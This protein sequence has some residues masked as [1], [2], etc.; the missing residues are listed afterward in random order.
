MNHRATI[1]C[2]ILAQLS[3]LSFSALGAQVYFSDAEA[4]VIYRAN[5]DG[6][7]VTPV[8]DTGFTSWTMPIEVDPVGQRIYWAEVGNSNSQIRSSNYSGGDIQ[9]LVDSTNTGSILDLELDL[10]NQHI[11]WTDR[12][13][14]RIER[15]NL[16]EADR[17][18]VT[19]PDPNGP[20][21]ISELVGIA[22]DIPNN[23][24]YYT[25]DASNGIVGRFNL[26]TLATTEFVDGPSQGISFGGIWDIELDLALGVLYFIDEDD[27]ELFSMN[28]DGTGFTNL[29]EP[30]DG[31]TP[32]GLELHDGSMYIAFANSDDV[33]S[34]PY[35]IDDD[36]F[37]VVSSGHLR[38]TGIAIDPFAVPELGLA[39]MLIVS[40]SMLIVTRSPSRG[41]VRWQ[42]VHCFWGKRD[43]RE[44]STDSSANSYQRANMRHLTQQVCNLIPEQLDR[45]PRRRHH[46]LTPIELFLRSSNVALHT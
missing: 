36:D 46:V 28:T 3:H 38:P 26:D 34:I 39:A 2:L 20:I 13:F 43:Q 9:T 21:L 18:N 4:G 25:S 11:Y 42:R 17:E 12:N 10:P 8:V 32:S 7:G 22:L 19:R 29:F 35:P 41:H 1:S 23:Y 5:P 44:R 24:I 16:N 40:L 30:S 6:S 27:S 15:M 45:R 37:G 33:I 14:D 31:N